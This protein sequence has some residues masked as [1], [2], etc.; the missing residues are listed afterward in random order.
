MVLTDLVPKNPCQCS[1]VVTVLPELGP[2]PVAVAV[3]AGAELGW[4]LLP[5]KGCSAEQQQLLG[6][7]QVTESVG[8]FLGSETVFLVTI[9][10]PEFFVSQL[11]MVRGVQRAT[12]PLRPSALFWGK[13]YYPPSAE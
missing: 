9:N 5:R 2:L 10:L 13:V 11:V 8:R 1:P 7:C 12:L 3:V 4:A 6:P